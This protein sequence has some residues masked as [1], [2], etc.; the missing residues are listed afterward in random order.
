MPGGGRRTVVK[1]GVDVEKQDVP[2]Q[3]EMQELRH[4]LPGAAPAREDLPA[5]RA[6]KELTS[7]EQQRLFLRMLL[8]VEWMKQQLL[9]VGDE[10]KAKATSRAG[11]QRPPS[12]QSQNAAAFVS[13]VNG[14]GFLDCPKLQKELATAVIESERVSDLKK[15]LKELLFSASSWC[16]FGRGDGGGVSEQGASSTP[17]M[18]SSTGGPT[19]ATSPGSKSSRTSTSSSRSRSRSSSSSSSRPRSRSSSSSR[20]RRAKEKKFG[21]RGPFLL[22]DD[23]ENPTGEA[24]RL[25]RLGGPEDEQLQPRRTSSRGSSRRRSSGGAARRG[26][27]QATTSPHQDDEVLLIHEAAHGGG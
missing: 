22:E 4:H 5:A 25:M 8:K 24:D 14:S 6:V 3:H 17:A 21:T 1:T 11:Q 18:V 16:P 2:E 15:M 19:M 23:I 27:R 20:S 7:A 10:E 12:G 9:D 13:S 26:R